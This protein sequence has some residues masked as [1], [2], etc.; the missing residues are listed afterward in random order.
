MREILFRGRR[1]DNGEWVEGSYC[2]AELFDKAGYEHFIIEVQADGTQ[3]KVDPATVGQWTGL[4]DKNGVKIFEGD[5]VK[6]GSLPC[7]GNWTLCNDKT[8]IT[9]REGMF[10]CGTVSLVSFASRCEVI[11]TIHDKEAN[12]ETNSI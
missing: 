8:A 2:K 7:T 3:Y 12:N 11:G 9:F 5:I 6:G 1:L 4:C 10:K